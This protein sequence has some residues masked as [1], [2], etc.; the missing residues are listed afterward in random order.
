MEQIKYFLYFLVVVVVVW[1]IVF[2]T[3]SQKQKNHNVIGYFHC[4]ETRYKIPYSFVLK[5]LDDNEFSVLRYIPLP[6]N[7]QA[8]GK[9]NQLYDLSEIE[10]YDREEKVDEFVWKKNF[11]GG[12][13]K[14]YKLKRKNGELKM[15]DNS[16]EGEGKYNI[17][18]SFNCK[19]GEEGKRLFWEHSQKTYDKEKPK[20]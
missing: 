2:L 17:V 10:T 7:I 8:N 18:T 6:E 9:P 11:G 14:L 12:A 20:F 15:Y 16:R 5:K 13:Y 1:L 3:D 19:Y 4:L